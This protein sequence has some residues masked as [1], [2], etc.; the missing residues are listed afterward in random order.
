MKGLTAQ[1][2]VTANQQ[3]ELL[4]Q[5]GANIGVNGI[6]TGNAKKS[7]LKTLRGIQSALAGALLEIARGYAYIGAEKEVL[8]KT[9]DILL[10]IGGNGNVEVT[11]KQDPM[12]QFAIN[13]IN[14]QLKI[15]KNIQS[16][17]DYIQIT[18][19]KVSGQLS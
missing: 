9:L 3:K 13:K 7:I 5:F 2:I 15:N 16:K 19:D 1:A 4:E 18:K 14:A 6:G 17:A 10:N 8:E 11:V 12:M